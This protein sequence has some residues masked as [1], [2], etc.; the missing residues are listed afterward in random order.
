M[1]PFTDNPSKTY[2]YYV[3]YPRDNMNT[4]LLVSHGMVLDTLH[5]S[6][7]CHAL[8]YYLVTSFGNVDALQMTTWSLIMSDHYS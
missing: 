3:Y 6:L 8:Y 4:K 2:L 5:I 7:M 1:V